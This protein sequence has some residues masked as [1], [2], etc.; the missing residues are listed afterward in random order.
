MAR[1]SLFSPRNQTIRFTLSVFSFSFPRL[2]ISTDIKPATLYVKTMSF[3]LSS[4]ILFCLPLYF[5]D[6]APIIFLQSYAI[7]L[8]QYFFFCLSLLLWVL[9]FLQERKKKNV[10]NFSKKRWAMSGSDS[11]GWTSRGFEGTT[12]RNLLTGPRTA[13]PSSFSRDINNTLARG[14]PP[15]RP[16]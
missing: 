11:S 8:L 1:S 5:L 7:G 10:Q 14:N 3:V 12:E 15:T 4:C 6:L 16:R 13:K 2:T 9:F